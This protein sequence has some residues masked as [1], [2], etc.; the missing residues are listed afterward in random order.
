M[1]G[2]NCWL[3]WSA[4]RNKSYLRGAWHLEPEHN[5]ARD[6]TIQPDGY[7]F[8]ADKLKKVLSNPSKRPLVLVACGRYGSKPNNR[9]LRTII[10]PALPLSEK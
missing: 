5:M 2:S 10:L 8:P 9:H 7:S 4:V 6:R 1:P 3:Q